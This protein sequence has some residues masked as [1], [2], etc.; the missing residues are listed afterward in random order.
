MFASVAPI[1]TTVIPNG[2]SRRFFFPIRS[3]ESVGSRREE[4]LFTSKR[5]TKENLS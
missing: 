2:V 1:I 5:S 3:C 4:S